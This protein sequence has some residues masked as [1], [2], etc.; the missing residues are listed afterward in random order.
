MQQSDGEGEFFKTIAIAGLGLIGGSLVKALRLK[1]F[2]GRII[3]ID[4]DAG[5]RSSAEASGLFDA[6]WELPLGNNG[7][8]TVQLLLLAVP[9][10]CFSQALD[11]LMPLITGETLVT[12]AGS[13]K[14]TVH[15]AARNLLPSGV[16]FIGGH[17][18][19]GSDRSGFS[20][21]SP[22][23]FENAYY[24]L[25]P[26]DNESQDNI[27]KLRRLVTLLG[28]IP[29]T[30]APE[31]H[32]ALVARLSHI[33]HLAA[34]AIV[35]TFVAGLPENALKYAGGGFRDSTRIAMGDPALWRDIFLHNRTYVIQGIDVLM[36]EL[37]RFKELLIQ[38]AEQGIYGNLLT[39]QKVRQGLGARRPS[40]ESSLYALV[41]DVEDKPGVLAAVTG[42]LARK[43]I[44]IKDIAIDHAREA[45]PGALILSF[46]SVQERSRAAESIKAAALCEVFIE[47][48]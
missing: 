5:A 28:A 32:D 34:S 44:N 41:L 12:D 24:F 4:A 43:Q 14:S 1:G 21:S 11:A 17:P 42:L 7:E 8:E 35:N 48:D 20:S 23:L 29:V 18:M 36:E 16:R 40:E 10:G 6:I 38:N 2:Q 3:G 13:V 25:T 31:E 19:A 33:P 30:I 26:E 37:H 39:S 45:L 15:S 47:Q 22:I 46:S 27:E 9:L